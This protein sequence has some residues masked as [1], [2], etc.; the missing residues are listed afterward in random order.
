MSKD[1]IE[2][3]DIWRHKRIDRRFIITD[4]GHSESWYSVLW[5][6]G[7]VDNVATSYDI[8]HYCEYKGKSKGKIKD[9]F[10]TKGENNEW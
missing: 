7:Y 9:L 3:G 8:H 5:E 6:N 1:K 4:T 10:E 2:V